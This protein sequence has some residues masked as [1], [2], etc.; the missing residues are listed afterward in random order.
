MLLSLH[1]TILHCNIVHTVSSVSLQQFWAWS[2]P[3]LAAI[4]SFLKNEYLFLK[5]GLRIYMQTLVNIQNVITRVTTVLVW[6]EKW[7]NGYT[8]V[9]N[10][11]LLDVHVQVMCIMVL[12]DYCD[13]SWSNAVVCLTHAFKFIHLPFTST[14][15]CNINWFFN[16]SK[17]IILCKMGRLLRAC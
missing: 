13:A 12:S 3:F 17:G 1:N 14:N 15:K 2:K 16:S 10:K 6:I 7:L 8:F 4:V 5:T 9:Q 11:L